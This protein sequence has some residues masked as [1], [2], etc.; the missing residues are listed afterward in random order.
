MQYAEFLE[1]KSQ[2]GHND[3]FEPLWM[4]EFLFDFQRHLVEWAVRKGRAAIFAGCGLGKTPMQLTW[5]ENVVKKTNG[6]VLIVTTLGDSSQTVREGEKFGVDCHRSRD[7]SLSSSQRITVTNYERLHY[8]SPSDFSGVVC[9]ESS[10]LKNSDGKTR[11]AVTEFLRTIRYRLLCTA[12][13]APNDYDELGNSS[14]AIGELGLRDMR[15]TFF[16]QSTSKDHLGWGRSKY[17]LRPYAIRDFWRWV[18]SWAR[19][20]RLPSDLGFDDGKFSLP[21]IH[22]R[23]HVVKARSLRP[24][25]LF[26]TPAITLDEQREERRR[27]LQERCEAVA[28]L[29]SETG[30][31]AIS[32]CHLNPEGDLLERLIP[33]AKQVKGSQSDDEKEELLNAFSLGQVRVLVTKPVIAAWGMNWQHCAHETFFPSHSYEQMYQA[34]RRCWR[35]GQER[36]V[37]VD[38]VSSEGEAGVL[39]NL[40]AKADASEAMFANLVEL[41]N[42]QLHIKRSK[43]FHQ[44][45]KCPSW[46]LSTK[47]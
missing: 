47:C 23:E 31:P 28:E 9:N 8:F 1:R 40:Q 21:P 37:V 33:D 34:I 39:D 16:R 17:L 44:Q 14:E 35:F 45:E 30:R 25:T 3:G 43:E 26:E 36:Q 7:G 18:C 15:T 13:P 46:L 41:M 29:V 2:V 24:G 10:I 22:Y 38:I 42:D 12:T 4:P 5:S 27:T 11:D 20:V 32:W 6:R 19:A